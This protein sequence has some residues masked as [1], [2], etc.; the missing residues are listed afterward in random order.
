MPW[1]R[2]EGILERAWSSRVASKLFFFS[3]QVEIAESFGVKVYSNLTVESVSVSPC[4]DV[5]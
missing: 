5:H 2:D 1:G 4:L 3:I